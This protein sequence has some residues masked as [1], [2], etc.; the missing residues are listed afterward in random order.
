[1]RQ[2]RF[3][4]WRGR[5]W[6]VRQ[7]LQGLRVELRRPRLPQRKERDRGWW[8]ESLYFGLLVWLYYCFGKTVD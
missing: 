7:Q 5:G 2:V 3:M 6:G 1:M 4:F 8:M